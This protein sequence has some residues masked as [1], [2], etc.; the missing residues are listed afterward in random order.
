MAA[1]ALAI[2]LIDLGP[3]GGRA[4][5]VGVAGVRWRCLA[6][7]DFEFGFPHTPPP[8]EKRFDAGEIVVREN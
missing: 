8:L 2:P 6:E 4:A 7:L 3:S 1:V 5:L